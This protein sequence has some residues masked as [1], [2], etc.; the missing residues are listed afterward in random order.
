MDMNL[1]NGMD[2]KKGSD[3]ILSETL[4]TNP[5]TFILDKNYIFRAET[6]EK[7][8]YDGKYGPIPDAKTG[9]VDLSRYGKDY[10]NL[11]MMLSE[12]P[13]ENLEY[14]N[15]GLIAS[16]MNN[17]FASGSLINFNQINLDSS[18][19][20]NMSNLFYYCKLLQTINIDNWNTENVIDMSGMFQHCNTLSSLNLPN[21]NTSSTANMNHMFCD[22][23]NLTSLNLS[24]FNTSNVV[25]MSYMFYNCTALT[26]LDISNF[27]TSNVT[28]MLY[29]FEYCSNLTTIH[30]VIDM[31][32]CI[33]YGGMFLHCDKLKN[34]K[35]KNPPSIFSGE[36]LSEDQY[37]IVS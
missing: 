11:Y 12:I 35:I 2:Y 31:K 37:V 27:D 25:D 23:S 9:M 26:E 10:I 4:I 6:I 3:Y 36:G 1:K 28:D 7:Y 13:K 24:N 19:V 15:S 34:V 8:N 32:S 21:L 14:L 18:N 22:C 5:Y 16:D 33:R 20:K 17:M 29:M 30:G